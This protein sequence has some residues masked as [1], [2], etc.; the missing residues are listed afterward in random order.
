MT[1]YEIARK[2]L[3]LLSTVGSEAHGLAL[4]G[5][6]DHDEMGVF[7]PPPEYVLGLKQLEHVVKRDR[8]EGVRSQ[9]GDTDLVLYN[10]RKFCGLA[11]KGNP[12]ILTLLFVEPDESTY[13]GRELILKRDMFASKRAIR[14]FL[15]FMTQQKERLEGSRGQMN[16]NRPELVEAYGFDTKYAM[17]VLRLGYQ[18]VE[19]ASTG[20]L[21]LPMSPTYRDLLLDVRRGEVQL[22][23]VLAET[24][25]LEK[26]LE[27]LLKTSLLPDE[28]DY[29]KANSWLCTWHE[30]F[31]ESYNG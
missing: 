6:E 26:Q 10:L 23:T 20:H 3:I 21:T 5:K 22:P 7:I 29:D 9:P 4:P 28:P 8:P 16:V 14:A 24:G 17:H 19:Y 30:E 13:L 12:S 25:H 27:N 18:G 11:L 1:N 15:G 31:W 2:G